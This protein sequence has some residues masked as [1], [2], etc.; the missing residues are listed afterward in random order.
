MTP[1]RRAVVIGGG[2]AGLMAA[3]T[4]AAAGIAVD[5]YDAMSNCGR[6]FLIA[7]KGG[8]NLTHAEAFPSFVARYGSRAERW[9]PMLEAFGADHLRDWARG[10]GIETFVGSSQRVFPSDLKA[11][12]LLRAWLRRLREAGVHFHLRHRWT[13]WDETGALRFD[14]PDGPVNVTSDATVLAL[15][16]G[17]WRRLGSDGRWTA[18]LA[19]RGIDIAALQ[20]SNCGFESGWTA[21]MRERSAGQPIKPVAARLAPAQG[22]DGVFHQG[23]FIFTS[24]GVEGSLI[25]ALSAPLRDAINRHGHAELEL[26]LLPGTP[27]D[28]L[29]AKLSLPR[30]KQSMAK[31]LHRCGLDGVKAA[32]L[33][34]CAP[35]DAFDDPTRLA[36][37]IKQLTVRL[38]RTRPIDE[39]IS[40]AGGVRFE[41][42]DTR[43]MLQ[44][45]PGVF[46]AGEMLDWEAPTGGYLLTAC[47]ASGRAAGLGAAEWLA[48]LPSA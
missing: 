19:A 6:K 39:A 30:G 2:P 25:Y 7:G 29:T 16:G 22:G 35:E 9:Q 42:V 37:A 1:A 3:E 28:K 15:G 45:L 18:T 31:H 11:A 23:E 12:P 36:L 10:L 46:C 40:T 4:L 8:L 47:F 20:P 34:E 26:D 44:A 5:V 33:R 41:A 14:A 24:V 43:L 32:V 48:A 13:G 17:S 21:I 27:L 38:T